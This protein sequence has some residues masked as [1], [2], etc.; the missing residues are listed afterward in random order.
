MEQW[1]KTFS[2][3]EVS[4]QI[5]V[6]PVT[7]RAWAKALEDAGY[8]IYRDPQAGRLYTERDISA[9]RKWKEFMDKNLTW[10]QAAKLIIEEFGDAL[11]PDARPGE[12]SDNGAIAELKEYM[13]RQEEF[14][15]AL[16]ERLECEI[17][18]QRN[19]IQE[20]LAA[21]AED[22]RYLLESSEEERVQLQ[23][24]HDELNQKIID[25]LEEQN[26]QLLEKVEEQQRYIDA[27]L[28]R[29]DEQ[30]M[31]TIRSMQANTMKEVAATLE[32]K[33]KKRFLGLF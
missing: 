13:Q 10:E 32:Q 9:L 7:L 15:K 20:I 18:D 19:Y 26:K 28:Q 27:T 5:D 14:N 2:A 24:R 25:K 23:Q 1:D 30:L 12:R 22:K 17:Q 33:K 3:R 16:V 11:A 31:Q 8:Q 29:R 4:Q 21:L 6:K